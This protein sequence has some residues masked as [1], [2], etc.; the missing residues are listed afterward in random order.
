MWSREK[1]VETVT[2]V[3]YRI[4][5]TNVRF[6]FF[7]FQPTGPVQ[8]TGSVR[9]A[10]LDQ[11]NESLLLFQAIARHS[12]YSKVTSGRCAATVLPHYFAWTSPKFK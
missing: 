4:H 1:V 11:P 10:G 3:Q 6:R 8:L 2:G 5:E 12:S 7:S 9:P